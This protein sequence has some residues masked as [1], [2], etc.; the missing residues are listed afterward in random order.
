LLY[1]SDRRDNFQSSNY[2]SLSDTIGPSFDPYNGG[3][4]DNF[5]RD[6]PCAVSNW[7]PWGTCSVTCGKGLKIRYRQYVN[8]DAAKR[9]HCSA[10]LR[11]SNHC[12]GVM[13]TCPDGSDQEVENY[14]K[15]INDS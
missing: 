14:Y 7:Y 4:R 12:Y 2:G 11:E 10:K 15:I 1:F 6:E 13:T 5:N 8:E 3:S 9:H